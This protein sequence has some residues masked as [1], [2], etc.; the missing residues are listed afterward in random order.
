MN[1]QATTPSPELFLEFVMGFRQTALIRAAVELDVFTAIAGGV[2]TPAGLA[3][4]CAASERGMRILCDALAISG[5]LSK[6]AGRYVLT[7]DSSFFLVR[8]SA[9]YIGDTIQFLLSPF[10]FESFARFT[11]AV[12][13]GGVTFSNQGTVAP[14]HPVWVDFAR[15][16]M[17][18]QRRAAAAVVELIDYGADAPLRVLDIAAGHGLY[19]ISFAQR[20]RNAEVTALDWAAVLELA[21]DNAG[22]AGVAGRYRTISGDAFS[23]D[24]GGPYDLVLLPNFL[25]HFSPTQCERLLKRIHGVLKNNGVVLTLEHV[26]DDERKTHARALMFAVIM[27]A[28][29]PEGDA[30]TFREYTRMFSNAGF[31]K[32]EL[33]ELEGTPN[34]LLISRK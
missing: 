12:R 32:T 13:R 5:Q 19:G 33:R 4:E 28:T 18:V 21:K 26:P 31:S 2:D 7:P 29:T 8:H 6:P 34:G 24:L 1:Q 16:M 14:D 15:A 20:Y 9:G 23:V 30:Y 3:R 27:L 10:M 22:R 17:N 11:D 25:H